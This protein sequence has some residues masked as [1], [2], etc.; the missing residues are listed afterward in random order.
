MLLSDRHAWEYAIS[1]F[2]NDLSKDDQNER[3]GISDIRNMLEIQK[4]I[5]ELKYRDAYDLCEKYLRLALSDSA[6]AKF[7]ATLIEISKDMRDDTKA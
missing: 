3:I 4:L 6:K 1:T 5:K 2:L 7:I